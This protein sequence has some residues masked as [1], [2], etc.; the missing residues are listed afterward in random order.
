ML[1]RKPLM[2]MK[3]NGGASGAS[4]QKAGGGASKRIETLGEFMEVDKTIGGFDYIAV[5]NRMPRNGQISGT[6]SELGEQGKNLISIG[7]GVA[8]DGKIKVNAPAF[9]RV[10]DLEKNQYYQKILRNI[11]NERSTRERTSFNSLLRSIREQSKSGTLSV[12]AINEWQKSSATTSQQYLS[13]QQTLFRVIDRYYKIPENVS[14]QVNGNKLTIIERIDRGGRKKPQIVEST[15]TIPNIFRGEG[16]EKSQRGFIK[17]VVL[18]AT[19][20]ITE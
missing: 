5:Y 15:T 9:L 4:R 20:K 1:Y 2:F 3:S 6:A 14:Y 7:F 11:E 13:E 19:K 8:F 10:K 16:K 17:S 12:G 18:Q